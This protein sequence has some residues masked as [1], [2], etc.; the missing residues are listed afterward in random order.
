MPPIAS[1]LPAALPT[2]ALLAVSLAFLVKQLVADFV[3]QTGWM[4]HGKERAAGW[5]APLAV[6][7]AV[8][9][10]ATAA[11]ALVVAPALVWLG[12]VDF[13]VHFAV[14]RGKAL[15]N[16]AT[17]ATP[18]RSLFWWLIGLDQTLHHATHLG[19][20]VMLVAARAA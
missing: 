7:A 5:V 4:A 3:L 20:V 10:V 6:H 12:L 13:V 17:G 19:F 9:A 1:T 8:H 2:A 16:R 11:I 15:V 18:D 14:D